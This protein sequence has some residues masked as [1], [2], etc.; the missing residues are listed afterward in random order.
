[1]VDGNENLTDFDTNNSTNEIT[2][3]YSEI[4]RPVAVLDS[5]D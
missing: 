4:K 2:E 1:V 3:T 5:S